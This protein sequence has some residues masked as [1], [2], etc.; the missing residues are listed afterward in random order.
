LTIN[1]GRPDV[2]RDGELSAVLIE[3]RAFNPALRGQVLADGLVVA[4]GRDNF[5]QPVAIRHTRPGGS[6]SMAV[7]DIR[8]VRVSVDFR[9]V[10]MRVVVGRRRLRA[11]MEVVV[12][13]VDVMVIVVMPLGVMGMAVAVLIPEEKDQR[14]DQQKRCK[15]FRHGNPFAEQGHGQAHPEKWGAGKD[16]LAAGRPQVLGGFNVEG[17]AH[18][19][20][21][22]PHAHGQRSS[23][24][25]GMPRFQDRTDDQVHCAGHQPLPKGALTGC[26]TVYQS[27]PMVVQSPAQA[28][29]GDQPQRQYAD[30]SLL[31]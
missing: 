17:N 10:P 30:L 14:D 13:A 25:A 8:P 1:P 4:A 16:H 9:L 27:G 12:V 5:L 29:P 31:P 20:S 23:V 21:D 24:N 18:A 7:M 19:V 22:S 2:N 28:C 26:D 11:R 6:V 3:R 15:R